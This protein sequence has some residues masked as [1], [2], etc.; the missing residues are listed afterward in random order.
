MD[1][2]RIVLFSSLAVVAYLLM[3]QWNKDYQQQDVQAQAPQVQQIITNNDSATEDNEVL[4]LGEPTNTIQ[5]A[6]NTTS[7]TQNLISVKTDTFDIRIN[8]KGGDIVYAALLNHKTKI[9]RA[10]CR[11]RV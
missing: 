8:P 6:T 4:K 10:S 11:E 7:S 9:G 5:T 3:L 2:K 1:V